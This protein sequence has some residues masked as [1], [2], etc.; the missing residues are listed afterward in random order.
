M[1]VTTREVET[2]NRALVGAPRPS[3]EYMARYGEVAKVTWRL[4]LIKAG[5]IEVKDDTYTYDTVVLQDAFNLVWA[6]AHHYFLASIADF[7]TLP[8]QAHS[9]TSVE[10]AHSMVTAAESIR[11]MVYEALAVRPMTDIELS[12]Y[13]EMSENTVRPRR[14]ELYHKGLVESIGKKKTPSNRMA[15]IW[16]VKAA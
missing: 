10:A 1:K 11:S 15:N 6:T 7:T 4:A 2:L 8:A 9:D 12:E 13:L 3:Q 14:V 16:G 5:I